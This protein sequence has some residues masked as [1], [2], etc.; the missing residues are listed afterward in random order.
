MI[1]SLITGLIGWYIILA[2]GHII[3]K[4]IKKEKFKKEPFINLIM[5]AIVIS[6]LAILPGLF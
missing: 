5:W 4:L 3:Y 2:I 6:F 1:E